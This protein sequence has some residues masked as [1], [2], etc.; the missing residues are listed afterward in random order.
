MSS[1]KIDLDCDDQFDDLSD[2]EDVIFDR[3]EKKI[4]FGDN[5]FYNNNDSDYLAD[6]NDSDSENIEYEVAL[7]VNRSDAHVTTTSSTKR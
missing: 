7:T 6:E 1:E 5:D 2:T 3:R 4:I